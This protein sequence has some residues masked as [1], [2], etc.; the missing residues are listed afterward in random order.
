MSKYLSGRA[1]AVAAAA[2][3]MPLAALAATPESGT[4]TLESGAIEFGSGPNVGV[5]VAAD[6]V[7]CLDPL[8]PC[9][10]FAL[11]VDLPESLGEYFP[12]AQMRIA[13][14]WD[15]PMGAGVED[16][17]I[18]MYDAAGKVVN[19]VATTD[20]PEKMT[21]LALG[22]LNE[23]SFEVIYY[24]V[25]SSTYT[26]HV[27]LDLGEPSEDVTDEELDD[28]FTQNSLV[29]RVLGTDNGAQPGNESVQR[30]S[31][32]GALGG[33]V[34]MLALAGGLLARRRRLA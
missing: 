10:Y 27:E 16:Y 32:A 12:S 14:S 17:D 19:S 6:F 9:D 4:L 23:Y 24:T 30:R 18:N 7:G 1:T 22:G 33:G 2:L 25:L 26:G 15:D 13:F 29:A 34:L 3:L 5:N 21:Q 28:F 8:L 31:S 20:N 11:S